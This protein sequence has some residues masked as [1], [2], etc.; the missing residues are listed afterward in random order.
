MKEE[1]KFTTNNH[2][3]S[4]LYSESQTSMDIQL[5]EFIQPFYLQKVFVFDMIQRTNLWLWAVTMAWN[6]YGQWRIVLSCLFRK[7][8]WNYWRS[9]WRACHLCQVFP[10]LFRWRPTVNTK[11]RVLGVTNVYWSDLYRG[12]FFD[13][14]HIPTM[15]K[16]FS[17]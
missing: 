14:L 11:A 7:N 8:H 16:L 6:F 9:Q 17:I 2:L 15:K 1:P 3:F 12:G 10:C 13:Y 4:F 5:I